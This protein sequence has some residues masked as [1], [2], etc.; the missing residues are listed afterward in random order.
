LITTGYFGATSITHHPMLVCTDISFLCG[1][2]AALFLTGLF[3]LFFFS[4][5]V[6]FKI[7]KKALWSVSVYLLMPGGFQLPRVQKTK[8]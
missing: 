1:H 8:S 3:F 5:K 7:F 6:R 2:G 4:Q